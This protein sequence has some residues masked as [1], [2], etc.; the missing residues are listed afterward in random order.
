MPTEEGQISA[1][2]YSTIPYNLG[3]VES[4]PKTSSTSAIPGSEH[5]EGKG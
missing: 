2:I 1:F 3:E 5:Y 4:E